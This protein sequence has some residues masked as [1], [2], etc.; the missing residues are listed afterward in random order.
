[1]AEDREFV[2]PSS[3]NY[4]YNDDSGDERDNRLTENLLPTNNLNMIS[5]S[6][7]R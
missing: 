2:V 7:L 4:E 6:E 5:V 1:M 3:I